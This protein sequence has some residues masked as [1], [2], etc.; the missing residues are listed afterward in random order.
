[1]EFNVP[2]QHKHGYIRDDSEMEKC[3]THQA[4]ICCC[5]SEVRELVNGSCAQVEDLDSTHESHTTI[6]NDDEITSDLEVSAGALTSG[7]G[8]D[9]SH[10]WNV[11]ACRR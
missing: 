8:N 3:Y 11:V 5:S 7:D 1:M 9:G 10:A 6:V 4:K 2:F